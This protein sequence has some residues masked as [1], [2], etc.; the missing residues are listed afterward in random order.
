ML[1][2]TRLGRCE[3]LF[4]SLAAAGQAPELRVATGFIVTKAQAQVRRTCQAGR[5]IGP[6]HQAKA[7]FQLAPTEIAQLLFARYSI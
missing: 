6:L 1:G 7:V 2:V 4:D 3:F 5:S